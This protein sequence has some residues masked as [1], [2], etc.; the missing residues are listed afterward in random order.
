[1]KRLL[2]IVALISF[3]IPIL[4]FNF[5][6]YL[7]YNPSYWDGYVKEMYY[8]LAHFSTREMDLFPLYSVIMG[9]I[10]LSLR[11]SIDRIKVYFK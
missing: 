9:M 5:L 11:L 2:T 6:L 10:F 8:I 4:W 1:M 3:I 7:T